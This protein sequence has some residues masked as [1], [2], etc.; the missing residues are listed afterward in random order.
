[1]CVRKDVKRS[2]WCVTNV[3]TTVWPET[4]AVHSCSRDNKAALEC[5]ETRKGTVQAKHITTAS[6]ICAYFH[7]VQTQRQ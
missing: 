5:T 3:C 2:G 6:S 4:V 7:P 1:M